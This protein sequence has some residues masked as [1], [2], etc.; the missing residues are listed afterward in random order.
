MLER[1][2]YTYW[3]ED[4]IKVMDTYWRTTE[5]YRKVKPFQCNKMLIEN[6]NSHGKIVDKAYSCNQCDKRSYT[7]GQY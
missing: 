3:R 5:Y 7:L 2:R 1:Y 6:E 4:F